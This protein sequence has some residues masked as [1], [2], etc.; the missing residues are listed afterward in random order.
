MMTSVCSIYRR[1][2]L[3]R[4]VCRLAQYQGRYAWLVVTH[5]VTIRASHHTG[6]SRL[7]FR[8]IDVDAFAFTRFS[9]R[10]GAKVRLDAKK[11][12]VAQPVLRGRRRDLLAFMSPQ[13]SDPIQWSIGNGARLSPE[14]A[15]VLTQ[16]NDKF[17]PTTTAVA[18]AVCIYRGLLEPNGKLTWD[19]EQLLKSKRQPPAGE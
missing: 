7:R 19:G 8:M 5:E 3:I 11:V 6:A 13:L 18:R 10:E 2:T 12:L 4:E 16:H 9:A 17:D 14:E 15:A 1:Q